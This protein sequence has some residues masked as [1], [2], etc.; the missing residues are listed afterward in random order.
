[1]PVFALS[2]KP[3]LAEESTADS[4]AT[5]DATATTTANVE[6]TAIS[7]RQKLWMPATK[8][9]ANPSKKQVETQTQPQLLLQ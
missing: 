7:V 2:L 9:T 5:L 4:T 8:L 1:M 3:A 6:T